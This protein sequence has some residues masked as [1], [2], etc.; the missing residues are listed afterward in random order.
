MKSASIAQ[1][2]RVVIFTSV[3]MSAKIHKD[4]RKLMKSYDFTLYRDGSHYSW[5][6]PNGAVVV[7]SKTP[8]KA[9][10]LKEIEKNIRRQIA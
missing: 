7:T 6:G 1:I 5:H 2:G 8:G 4:L 3:D 9:R 10:W